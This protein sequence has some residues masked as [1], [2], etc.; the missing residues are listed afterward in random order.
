MI[1]S[2]RVKNKLCAIQTAKTDFVVTV[3]MMK[4]K[5]IYRNEK[6]K[7]NK[8]RNDKYIVDWY[9]RYMAI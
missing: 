2:V 9:R 6:S 7:G 8:Y 5:G 3:C 4:K 1:G